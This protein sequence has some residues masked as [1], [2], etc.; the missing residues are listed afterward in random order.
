MAPRKK[1]ISPA[2]RQRPLMQLAPES[3]SPD[4]LTP[5][6]PD[7]SVLVGSIAL[8]IPFF[9]AAV[10][11]GERIYRQRTCT[12]CNGSGLVKKGRF[13]KRCPKCGGFLPWQSWKRF[14]TG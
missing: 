9:V 4:I 13:M 14:F 6:S 8:S 7:V 10:L 11:F 2:R 5:L 3:L 1:A 12:Q